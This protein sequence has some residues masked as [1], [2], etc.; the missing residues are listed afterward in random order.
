[1]SEINFVVNPDI[2]N[3]ETVMEMVKNI[4]FEIDGHK[5]EIIGITTKTNFASFFKKHFE[6]SKNRIFNFVTPDFLQE[7]CTGEQLYQNSLRPVFFEMKFIISLN[8]KKE[9]ENIKHLISENGGEFKESKSWLV[10]TPEM[11]KQK[12]LR[13]LN[14]IGSN[15]KIKIVSPEEVKKRL[16]IVYFKVKDFKSSTTLIKEFIKKDEIDVVWD[17][18]R[19][20]DSFN[21]RFIHISKEKN[22]SKK[23]DFFN[24]ISTDIWKSIVLYIQPENFKQVRLTSKSFNSLFYDDFYWKSMLESELLQHPYIPKIDHSKLYQ[25]EKKLDYYDIYKNIYFPIFHDRSIIS[26]E[27][28]RQKI[29]A[30]KETVDKHSQVSLFMDRKLSDKPPLGCSKFGGTPDLPDSISWPIG[31]NFIC[32]IN[33]ND[34]SIQNSLIYNHIFKGKR[35][36]LYFFYKG[37]PEGCKVIF[38]ETNDTTSLKRTNYPSTVEEFYFNHKWNQCE[39]KGFDV[40]SKVRLQDEDEDYFYNTHVPKG[41]GG[42][43]GTKYAYFYRLEED[44]VPL[45]ELNSDDTMDC[46]WSDAGHL[47]FYINKDELEKLNFDNA[48]SSVFLD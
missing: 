11:I 31:L 17:D 25:K 9:E 43:F 12:D 28:I 39:L 24:D 36:I 37:V 3:Q 32:Q 15:P 38:F 18:N 8:D 10:T 13:T 45:L 33:L 47:L 5:R 16:E 23:I 40:I 30:D 22:E 29:N 27:I 19:I 26:K 6:A 1:M 42:L 48:K 7:S 41:A 35:G 2:E 20:F 34:N 21:L 46:C 44:D 4:K 14:I